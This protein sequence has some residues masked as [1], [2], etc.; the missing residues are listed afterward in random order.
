MEARTDWD[1]YPASMKSMYNY[2]AAQQGPMIRRSGTIWNQTAHSHATKSVVVPFVFSNEQASVIEISPDRIRFHD[3][4]GLETYPAVS[5]TQVV[6]ESPFV[7]RAPGLGAA[8]D[9]EVALAGFPVQL[10]MQNRVG[11][12]TAVNADDYTLDLSYANPDALPTTG[13]TAA[14]VYHIGS[15]YVEEVLQSIRVIQKRD[16]LFVF[17]NGVLNNRVRKLQRKGLRN[18][19][20]VDIDLYDGPYL[21]EIE[22]GTHVIPSATGTAAT[23]STGTPSG[24]T[25]PNNAF[26]LNL[27]SYW[28]GSDD[29]QG[30]LTF[31]A[32]TPFKCTGYAITIPPVSTSDTFSVKDYGP[33]DWEFQGYDGSNWV[34]LDSQADYVLYDNRRSVWFTIKD[35]TA[36]A[37]YR[38]IVK[39]CTRGGALKPRIAQLWITS[40]TST[41]INLSLSKAGG[42]NDGRGFL[43]TDVGRVLRMRGSDGQWSPA[44]I[45]AYSSATSVTAKLQ[46]NPLSSTVHI[47][48]WR[49][50][51]W[52]DTTGWPICGDFFDKRLI[53]GG[54]EGSPEGF[55]MSRIDDFENMSPT[56]P[57][58]EVLDD[59]AFFGELSGKRLAHIHWIDSDEKAVLI[60]TSSGEWTITAPD[61]ATA[62][63]PLNNRARR[64]TRRGCAEI[65]AL[66]VDERVLYVQRSRRNIRDMG[67]VFESDGYRVPS[68][69]TFAGHIGADRFAEMDYAAEPHSIVWIRQ[70]NGWIA[71]FTYNIDE[72]VT[73]WH[74]H[75][76][77]GEVESM[78]V[79]PAADQFQDI[80]WLVVKRHIDGQDVRYIERLAP[81]W[82]FG[83]VR[84]ESHY[85]DAGIS[86]VFAEEVD[87]VYGLWHLEGQEAYGIANGFEQEKQVITNGAFKL[88]EPS[89][90]RITIGLPFES[91]FETSRPDV[92]A[93]DGTSMGKEKRTHNLVLFV[94][95][96]AGGEFGKRDEED[97]E[98]VW[99]AI[100]YEQAPYDVID[101]GEIQTTMVGPLQPPG[102]YSKSDTLLIRQQS[103]LP[104][105]MLA[106]M[107]Q[108]NTQDRG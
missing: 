24:G 90:G 36:F 19:T 51:V 48:R 50:G 60:G 27:D 100:E 12:V 104:L 62:I 70:D 94:W 87:T 23:T 55:A 22:D 1:R 18:W 106:M 37:Q 33:G 102:G 25:N 76:V 108:M 40:D 72:G 93:Q 32:N 86:T 67:Y 54:S 66:A 96:S 42:I 6:S 7:I 79:V 92:G 2:I 28:E 43:S 91:S 99:S 8:V 84:E 31:A 29:Q 71:G 97:D 103:P 65:D 52:S 26:D 38:I 68:R 13:A 77:G 61:T 11:T 34:T 3:E 98:V 47:G 44:V 88:T 80:L 78:C 15:P 46:A 83:S 64:S 9:D 53:M 45:T 21:D 14:R 59:S 41:S 105:N 73:G 16:T 39:A 101:T 20:I 81:F 35:D 58:G 57:G 63:G 107:P 49:P 82:D 85:V 5:I 95:D 17:H 69:S 89:A 4:Q 56:D 74:R 75:Y 10:N 30:T